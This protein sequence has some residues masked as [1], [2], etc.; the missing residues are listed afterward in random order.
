MLCVRSC[1]Y[2]FE[3]CAGA[4]EGRLTAECADPTLG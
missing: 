4:V 1:C 2:R 3:R